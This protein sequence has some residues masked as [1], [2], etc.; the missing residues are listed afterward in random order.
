MQIVRS[1]SHLTLGCYGHLFICGVAGLYVLIRT[2]LRENTP[3][4][5]GRSEKILA[6][7]MPTDSMPL[8]TYGLIA[9]NVLVYVAQMSVGDPFTTALALWPLGAGFM[10]WQLV[11]YAFV[12]GGASHI[13]FNVYGLFIFGA[14]IEYRWGRWRYLNYYLSCVVS[15]AF[16]QL[17]VSAFRGLVYPMLGASGGVFGL[18]LAFALLFPTRRVLLLLPP[19]PMRAI[20]FAML[21]GGI[22][23]LLGITGTQAGVAHFAHLGGM[24]GGYVLLRSGYGRRSS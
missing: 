21:Y 3:H 22:E 18:L 20:T 15:A 4:A 9:T 11:S 10:P 17:A 6:G 16:A 19:I 7:A 12:H 23:L 5:A 2:D 1:A 24:L 14:D 8:M 13:L